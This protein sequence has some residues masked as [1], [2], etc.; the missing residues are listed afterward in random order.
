MELDFGRL[1]GAEGKMPAADVLRPGGSVGL[2]ACMVIETYSP[3]HGRRPEVSTRTRY[4]FYIIEF[5]ERGG[6]C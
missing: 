4:L 1:H 2:L 3:E 5:A 6:S